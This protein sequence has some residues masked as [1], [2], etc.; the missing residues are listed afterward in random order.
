MGLFLVV[1][2][3]VGILGGI[4]GKNFYVADIL[5]L[6][7]FK[8]EQKRSTWSGRLIFLAVGAFLIAVGIK[9]LMAAE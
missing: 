5:S 7:G 1:F 2:G 6:S 3:I 4:F 9:L 8:H